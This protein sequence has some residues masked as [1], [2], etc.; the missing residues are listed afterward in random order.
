[1]CQTLSE[2]YSYLSDGDLCLDRE[3]PGLAWPGCCTIF[4]RGAQADN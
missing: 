3:H 1:M 4:S 2:T